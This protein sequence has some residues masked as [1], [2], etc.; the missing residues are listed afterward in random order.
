M[1]SILEGKNIVGMKIEIDFKSCLHLQA[2]K[3]IT[4]IQAAS[5]PTSD[6]MKEVCRQ[7][8]LPTLR[9]LI[10]VR[11]TFIN[12]KDFSQQYFLIRDDTFIRFESIMAQTKFIVLFCKNYNGFKV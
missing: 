1:I 7:V 9:C 10:N 6:L 5:L 3:A 11:R 2:E 4:L 12:F 8:S